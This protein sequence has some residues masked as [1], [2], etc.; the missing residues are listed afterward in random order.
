MVKFLLQRPIAVFMA[1]LACFIVGF[2][3]YNLLPVSM[4]P[5]IAIPQITVQVTGENAS[6][7]ELENTV[8]APVRRQLLQVAGL[9][10]LRSE[11]RDGL[12][13]VRLEFDFGTNTDLAFIEVNEKIDAA[14][15]SLSKEVARP[16]AMKASATDIPVLYVNMTLK[17][18]I[19]YEPTTESQFLEMCQLA[20]N[21]VKRRIEQLPEVAIADITGIPG[22]QL[23]IVPDNNRMAMMG[24]TIEDIERALSV[25]NVEPG[26]MLVRDGYYEYNIRMDNLLRTPEDVRNI[27]IN[28]GDRLFQLKDFCQIDVASKKET[29]RSLSAGKRAVT[30][31]IIKQ[32]DENMD[33]MKEKL[34]ETIDYFRHNYPQVDFSISRNQTELL[35]YTISN[36]QQ[37][38]MLGLLFIF[39]V[40]V[41]FLGDVRSP[42]VI[43]ISM[44]VSIVITFFLFYLFGVSLNV[45]S[46]S[47]LILAVGM[48]IDSSIIVT[49]NISQYKER[50]YTLMDAC[51]AGT[52]E[53]ITPMLSSNLTTIAVFV[54]LIFMSG[55]AGAIF[56]DQA[57]S[58]TVGLAVSYITGIMLLPVLYFLLYSKHAKMQ[59]FKN[60]NTPT[61]QHIHSLQRFYDRGIAWVFSHKALTLTLT[62]LTIPACIALF[63]FMKKERMPEIDQN[64]LIARIEWNE[65]IHVE[66]N[67]QRVNLLLKSIEGQVTEHEVYVGIQDYLLAS[68]TDE[69]T[70]TEAEVYLKTEEPS[71]IAPLQQAVAEWLKQQYGQAVVTFSPPETIFEKLFVT[72]EPDVVAKLRLMNRNA[73]PEPENLRAMQ[74]EIA[75]KTQRQTEDIPWSSQLNL[76]VDH[77]KLLLYNVAYDEVDRVL[78]T[79]FRENQASTLHSY[80][81][82]LTISIAGEERSVNRVLAETLV[83]TMPDAGG[84]VYQI[85]LRELVKA[86]PSEDLKSII[87][88]DNGEYVPLNYY[89]AGGEQRLMNEVRSVV[90]RHADWDVDFGGSFLDNEAM[91]GEL[92]IILLVSVL[93]MYFIMCAQFESFLQPLIVLAEIPIDTAFALITL[94]VFGHTLNLMSAIGIIVTCGIVV[95]DSILKLDSINELRKQGMPLYEAIHTAGSRRLRPIIMTSLTTIFAMVPL[96]FTSDMGSEMQRPLAIAMIGAMIMGTLVS[97]FVVPLIYYKM[98]KCNNAK[99]Q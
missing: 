5:D 98:Q 74:A 38:L 25:N 45:I 58:I 84:Q 56:T 92:A 30:L 96:L 21:I 54:P 37:N 43:G 51:A 90:S 48:M 75:K 53:M 29:G 71:Q 88:D 87:A 57:F 70:A 10:E 34:N 14:M 12:G 35:D 36:L 77:E 31:A 27:Y 65:N 89:L 40:S 49:E 60:A 85:P 42:L 66:E 4:L 23:Q 80:Q 33:R 1:F 63:I 81:Q 39:I 83:Q 68:G 3:T 47:G 41:F 78:R 86:E 6:A 22:Q 9:K 20:E 46:L 50:G 18:D 93:L 2:I 17:N 82:Y 15:N 24:V 52:T 99:M 32:S 69:L 55:I 97:L 44:V 7:R 95:N 72:G 62:A 8:V 76:R 16:K 13:L 67:N 73:S 28:K 59:I 94:W 11:T 26:S 61:R 91:L 19:A 64:E 79:A